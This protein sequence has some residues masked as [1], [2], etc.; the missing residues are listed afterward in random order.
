VAEFPRITVAKVRP[1]QLAD[2]FIRRQI[3]AAYFA[4]CDTL[5]PGG[6][7]ILFGALSLWIILKMLAAETV[8]FFGGNTQ[9]PFVMLRFRTAGTLGRLVP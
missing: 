6:G 5:H 3:A 1:P 2:S 4:T 7:G 8:M 9:P